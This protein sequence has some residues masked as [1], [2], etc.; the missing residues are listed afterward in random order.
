MS[1][2]SPTN[3]NGEGQAAGKEDHGMTSDGDQSNMDMPAEFGQAHPLSQLISPRSAPRDLPSESQ[4][5]KR[6][7]GRKPVSCPPR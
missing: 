5:P 1:V 6:K 7:G 4:P 3:N 2:E